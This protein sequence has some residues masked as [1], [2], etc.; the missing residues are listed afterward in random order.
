MWE[1]SQLK[2][3]AKNFLRKGYWIPFAVSLIIALITNGPQIYT[4]FNNIHKTFSEPSYEREF[5]EN[6]YSE[7]DWTSEDLSTSITTLWDDIKEELGTGFILTFLGIFIA[8]FFVTLVFSIA[9]Q[10]LLINPL[11]VGSKKFFLEGAKSGEQNFSHL[12]YA[13]KS[14]HFG[15]VI[16][17]MFMTG[18]FRFLWTLLLVI[19]GIIKKYA[20]AMVPYIISEEPDLPYNEAIERSIEMTRGH[21]WNMFVLD[22]SFLGWYLLGFLACFIG[23][24]FVHPYYNA[25]YA[26]LY[27]A[28]KSNSYIYTE[29][30][31]DQY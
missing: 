26:E 23:T 19:P 20:Y 10:V 29:A 1:R 5:H 17:T 15:K 11:I 21:K 7:T 31:D 2:E 30:Y 9:I 8:I 4:N 13:F 18:L 6:Y 12:G 24:F 3:N 16:K 22:L 28:L 27:L 25:T 14:N